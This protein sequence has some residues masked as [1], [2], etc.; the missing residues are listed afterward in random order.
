[1]VDPHLVAAHRAGQRRGLQVAILDHRAPVLDHADLLKRRADEGVGQWDA[2]RRATYQAMFGDPRDPWPKR[3]FGEVAPSVLGKMLDA[4]RG[5]DL[6]QLPYLR[7]VNVRWHSVQTADVLRMGF[8]PTD[9]LRFSLEPGDLLICEGGEPG[10]CAIWEGSPNPVYF[11][12][13]LHRARPVAGLAD[14]EYLAH[15]IESMVRAGELKDYVSQATIA[16]LT[17]QKLRAMPVAVPP[18][19]LQ[20]EFASHV[21]KMKVQARGAVS[22]AERLGALGMA[23]RARAFSGRL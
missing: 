22:R 4:K 16:H 17:G 13:A 5:H 18:Y 7:N 19:S 20:I 21:R 11:Q 10:R 12:K 1:M 6:P 2:L 14:A 9:Q 3:A 8:S 15:S 23:L